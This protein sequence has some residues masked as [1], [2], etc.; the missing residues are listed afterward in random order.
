M[1]TK[2]KSCSLDPIPTSILFEFMDDLLPF[3]TSMCNKSLLEGQLPLSQRHALVTPILKKDGLDATNVQNYRPISNLTYISKLVERMVSQQLTGFL[4]ESGLLPKLQSGFRARHSTETATLRVLS[5]V[6]AAADRRGVTLLGLLDMSAAFD[7]VDHSILLQRAEVSFGL[8]GTVLSWLTSFL[9]GRTQQVVLNGAASSVEKIT[10]GVPQGSVLGP[11]LFL[12]YTADIPLIAQAFGLGVH[13]YAD[14][15]QLYLSGSAE[16]SGAS[17]SVVVDCI[18][19]MDRWMASNRLKL[20]ADKTQFIWLGSRQQLLKVEIDSIQLGSGSVSLKSS[21]NNLGVIFDSQLSMRDHVRHVCR[22]CFYQLRQL[23][24]VRRSLTFEASAQ[25]VH[26]FINSRLDYC[27]S[28]LA[29]VSDQLIGQL[30]SVLRA[31]ARLV[32]QK[33]KFDR[34]SDDIRN[35][36]HW[37][38]IRQR[39]SFKLCLLVF[40]CLRGEAPPYLSEMLALVSDSDALRS[41]RSAARGDL[42]I[43]R[44]FTKTFGPRGF[45]VSGPTAW[46]ALPP[47]LKNKDLS[48]TVFR[49]K[50]K[51]HLF[52]S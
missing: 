46:N 16:S 29:G 40:R 17:I 8:S 37:L 44:T 20:N 10:S 41:H 7:T 25:L 32:L 34:I 4:D 14:D 22:S 43:P 30:Q 35:K 5:D 18:S 19:E 39:I 36:L 24:V 13:C 11:L 47:S 1:S 31:A 28:L 23:R 52:N 26:A 2:P 21:V 9:D 49:S 45:A 6:L 3:I 42:I 12:L 51:T 15:G 50:L 48:P 27:N 33:K 38:P